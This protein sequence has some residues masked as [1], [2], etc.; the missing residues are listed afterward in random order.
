[1]AQITHLMQA[2]AA[3]DAA[4]MDME[5]AD[6]YTR[7]EESHLHAAACRMRDVLEEA[8]K[9]WLEE[10]ETP[11]MMMIQVEEEEV[12]SRSIG[13]WLTSVKDVAYHMRK[14]A[15]ERL[16]RDDDEPEPQHGC[17]KLVCYV[18]LEF[19]HL[20][21]SVVRSISNYGFPFLQI[22][23]MKLPC[24]A[25]KIKTTT[26]DAIRDQLEALMEEYEG[27]RYTKGLPLASCCTEQPSCVGQQSII[28]DVP[29]GRERDDD[30][31]RIIGIITQQAA[32]SRETEADQPVILSIFGPAG[33]G[34][35]TLVKSI[36]ND[37]ELFQDY[38][39][40]W[41]DTPEGHD[42]KKI[43]TSI[44][45]SSQALLGGAESRPL[46]NDDYSTDAITNQLAELFGSG[47]RK[48][49]LVLDGLWVEPV[50]LGGEDLSR[51]DGL[52]SLLCGIG[53]NLVVIV[54]APSKS[55]AG[56]ITSNVIKPYQLHPLSHDTCWEIMKRTSGFEARND[57]EAEAAER[58][59]REIASKCCGLPLAAKAL[60]RTLRSVDN[61]QHWSA[62]VGDSQG[63]WN[64]GGGGLLGFPTLAVLSRLKQGYHLSHT[65]WLCF[66]TC[67]FCFSKGRS[68]S[69]SDIHWLWWTLTMGRFKSAS[70]L[71][72]SLLHENSASVIYCSLYSL[73]FFTGHRKRKNPF[74]PF[75]VV[76]NARKTAQF[77][78]VCV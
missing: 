61:P 55:V 74:T 20:R 76:V 16:L 21:R 18:V 51:M 41:V 45:S 44:I 66:A 70:L 72:H 3:F 13:D 57:E 6:P 26:G 12:G 17:N 64:T 50:R 2:K 10:E 77:G 24:L 63:I 68:I 53:R 47:N 75:F 19:T 49:L 54:T 33:I 34:K 62:A 78:L 36:F 4:C 32:D 1:M 58:I 22:A 40:A 7:P 42:L 71:G 11:A 48:L 29:L 9:R 5:W 38:A 25:P 56:Y 39:K 60:G 28:T 37:P 65:E 31:Q 15:R 30:K 23:R 59:G 43:Y 8:E 73:H 35:T 27:F 52:K 14:H 69:I 46:W 67:A